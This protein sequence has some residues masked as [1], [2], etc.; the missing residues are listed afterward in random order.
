MTE[1]LPSW[2]PG[3]TRDA[4][5]AFLERAATVPVADRV[6]YFD[7]DGT[8]WCERPTYVQYDFFVDVLRQR[9]AE[10]PAL[11]E[12]DEFAALLGGDPAAIEALGLPADRRSPGR[13]VRGSDPAAVRRRGAGVHGPGRAPDPRLG[14]SAPSPTGRCSS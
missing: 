5:L 10:D 9:V 12:R 11:A 7:N 1:M 4:L 3:A 8:L 14:R 2:R 13:S 6:A